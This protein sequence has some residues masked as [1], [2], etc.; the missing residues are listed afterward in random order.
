MTDRI[1]LD[2]LNS[3]QYDAL[4][5]ELDQLR[6]ALDEVLRRFV[7]KGH[8]GAPCLSSGWINETTVA[9]WRATLYSPKQV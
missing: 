3:D 7:H 9:R 8:P 4:H 1:P 6:A 2:E 5:A